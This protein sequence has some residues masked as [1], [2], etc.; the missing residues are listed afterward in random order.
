[1]NAITDRIIGCGIEVHKALGPGL[2]ESA[3]R[4]CLA[5]ELD[6]SGVEV[7]TEVPVPLRYRATE[8]VCT[9]RL[10][11][12]VEE[13]VIVEIKSVTRLAPIHTAQM[14]TYLRLTGCRVG[15]LMNFN[16]QRLPQGIKRV[17]L[18]FPS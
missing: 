16:V 5:S 2:L 10:D 8:L 13:S 3:Y 11:L 12:L 4:Q 9:Y 17:V 18:G 14:I 7:R 15:L 1:M 6:A